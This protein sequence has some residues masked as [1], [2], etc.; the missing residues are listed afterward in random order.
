MKSEPPT[1]TRAPDNQFTQM[2][3]YQHYIRNTNL[4]KFMESGSGVPIPS[5]KQPNWTRW[6]EKHFIWETKHCAIGWRTICFFSL[7]FSL[8]ISRICFS[9]LSVFPGPLK[10][11]TTTLDPSAPAVRKSAGALERLSGC[12][13]I[14]IYI[15]IYICICCQCRAAH[16]E[17]LSAPGGGL[18]ALLLSRC[19]LRDPVRRW[20][21]VYFVW[22]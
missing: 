14:Y 17:S 4:L 3:D 7:S 22:P 11:I 2:Q 16:S 21:Y 18:A 10:P 19:L 9:V 1:P 20:S 15:Y 5:V 12:V 6:R 13:Y 8:N